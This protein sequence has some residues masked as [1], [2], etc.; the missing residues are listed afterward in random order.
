MS[1]FPLLHVITEDRLSLSA[2]ERVHVENVVFDSY[3]AGHVVMYNRY[4]YAVGAF[5]NCIDRFL[6]KHMKENGSRATPTANDGVNSLGP[7]L[8]VLSLTVAPRSD[9]AD[10]VG[11]LIFVPLLGNLDLS[12]SLRNCLAG[13]LDALLLSVFLGS[14]EFSFCLGEK[15]YFEVHDLAQHIVACGESVEHET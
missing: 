11:R 14:Y 12:S 8:P 5:R 4:A 9:D 3:D 10:E 2:V 7:S 6:R 13:N 1:Q 15:R